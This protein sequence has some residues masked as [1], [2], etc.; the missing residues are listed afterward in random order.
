MTD[1]IFLVHGM[2]HHPGNWQADVEARIR[3]DYARYARLSRIP[4]DQRFSLVPVSYDGVFRRLV[5]D[6]QANANALGPVAAGLGAHDV[7]RLIGWL[8]NA[9][10][11]DNNFVWTHAA[12]VLL[13]RFFYTVRQEIK[14]HVL[15]TIV[16]VIDALSGSANWSIISHSLGTAVIHDALDMLWNATNE[17]GTATGFEPRHE[18]ALLLAMVANVSRVLQTRP[19]A[20]E[21]SVKPGAAGQSGRGC[22]NFITCRHKLDPF[23]IPKMFR[24]IQWPDADAEARGV[25]RYIEVDHIHQVNVHGF[26]HYLAHPAVHIPIFRELTFRSAVTIDEEADALANFLP[27][28]NIGAAVGIRIR[29]RL[30][31]IAPGISDAWTEYRAIWDQLEG[32]INEF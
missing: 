28:G 7:E 2:G 20:Y 19:K 4:F 24:P 18:Q 3:A 31:E 32:V 8:K 16:P 9:G 11:I 15:N 10:Q 25:Y 27:F 13:Y 22:L 21:S 23:C 6:W 29:Q 30:E 5:T 12:D 14:T 1:T 26:D 17:D